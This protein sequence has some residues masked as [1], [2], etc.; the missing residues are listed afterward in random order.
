MALALKA[1]VN[2]SKLIKKTHYLYW[3]GSEITTVTTI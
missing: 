3:D 1:S 2:L